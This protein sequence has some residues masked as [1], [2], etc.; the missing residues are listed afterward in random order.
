[1][2]THD[3]EST[4]ASLGRT[5]RRTAA[6][7]LLGAL[8]VLGALV[9]SSLELKNLERKVHDKQ[10]QLREAQNALVT[11][12]DRLQKS[13]EKTSRGVN[14]ARSGKYQEAIATYNE[15]LEIDPGNYFVYEW[16][17]YTYYRAGQYDEALRSYRK[18]I[19]LAPAYPRAY[20]NLALVLWAR[21]DPDAAVD[22]VATAIKLDPKIR[23]DFRTDPQFNKFR[24]SP[25]FRALIS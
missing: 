10:E 2:N 18:L 25:R 3:Y 23:E 1:M 21:N 5:S 13:V 20:Y 6:L 11:A 22:V 24:A 12:R 19:D 8:L 4:L 14:L 9:Y 7:S 16:M 17:G 15:A